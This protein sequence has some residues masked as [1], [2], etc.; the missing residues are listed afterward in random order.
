MLDVEWPDRLPEG[1][2]Q[3]YGAGQL[4]DTV[5]PDIP[6]HIQ[7]D[8]RRFADESVA[9]IKK[10]IFPIHALDDEALF[11]VYEL[12]DLLPQSRSCPDFI[13]AL[14]P[15]R[16]ALLSSLRAFRLRSG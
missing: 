8:A 16:M 10:E 3:Q 4:R 15:T 12:V 6:S 9:G 1:F 14:R 11:G 13:A 7:G 2:V 5:T